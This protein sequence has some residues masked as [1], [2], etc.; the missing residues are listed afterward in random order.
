MV[1]N[2]DDRVCAD[3]SET[4][5]MRYGW[6]R[7]AATCRPLADRLTGQQAMCNNHVM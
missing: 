6:G 3:C 2:R 1:L 5:S 4:L 7:L